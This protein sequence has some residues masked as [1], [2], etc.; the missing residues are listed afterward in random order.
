MLFVFQSTIRGVKNGMTSSFESVARCAI[1]SIAAVLRF[2]ACFSTEFIGVDLAARS[3]PL[4][5]IKNATSSPSL[6]PANGRPVNMQMDFYAHTQL[7]QCKVHDSTRAYGGSH[8]H[9][10]AQQVH[11]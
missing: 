1:E 7:L 6:S 2:H 11:T 9:V 5:T 3:Q 10:V 4:H 8:V